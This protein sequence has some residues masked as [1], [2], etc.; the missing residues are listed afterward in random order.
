MV[1]D[2]VFGTKA[3]PLLRQCS[4]SLWERTSNATGQYM[5]RATKKSQLAGGG[6]SSLDAVTEIALGTVPDAWQDFERSYRCR[7]T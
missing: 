6:E 4:A 7:Q 5:G 2:A 1:A 3:Q